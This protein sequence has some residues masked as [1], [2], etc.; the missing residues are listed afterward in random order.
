MKAI[1][2]VHI[3]LEVVVGARD[4]KTLVNSQLI[5]LLR[6]RPL[7]G[8]SVWKEVLPRCPWIDS[9]LS[10]KVVFVVSSEKVGNLGV[11]M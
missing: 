10:V 8:R 5:Q 3:E 9:L 1:R 11:A 2:V 6:G 4:G 7:S